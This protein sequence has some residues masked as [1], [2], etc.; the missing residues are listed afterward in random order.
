MSLISPRAER[1]LLIAAIV[2]VSLIF[3]GQILVSLVIAPRLTIRSV[4]LD[5][6]LMLEDDVF[7]Q[8]SG[9]DRNVHYFSL[10]EDNVEERIMQIPQVAEVHVKKQFPNGLKVTIR[11]RK[12]MALIWKED[13]GGQGIYAVDEEGVI[14]QNNQGMS[15]WDLPVISG[16]DL[17]TTVPGDQLEE[18]VVL[19]LKDL[20]DLKKNQP[21]YY[22]ILSEVK[23][24]PREENSYTMLVYLTT[25]HIAAHCS[26]PLNREILEK[27]I[28]VL[29][30]LEEEGMAGEVEEVD[31]RLDSVRYRRREV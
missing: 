1:K 10:Q 27:A 2:L 24:L 17:T 4:V 23:I 20:A 11:K 28:L 25:H 31:I 16:V 26:L 8:I 7:Y 14:F 3:V 18:S 13:L 30:V 22:R 15:V 12:A 5:S 29:D 19:L 6:D 9:L 21:S